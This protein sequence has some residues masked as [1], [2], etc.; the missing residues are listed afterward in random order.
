VENDKL[1]GA[2]KDELQLIL[3]FFPRVESKFSVILAIDTGMI[4]FLAANAPPFS[5][6]SKW[7]LL[8]SGATILLLA[9]SI[10]MLYRGSFPNLKGGESSLVY[11]REIG[12]RREH[13][14]V[15]EFAAQNEK[16]YGHDLLGQVWRNSQI[17]S[18]K[19]D[20]LKLAFTSLALAIPAWI[21]TLALFAAYNGGTHPAVKP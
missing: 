15:E 14:F 6:F 1:I 17:L 4:G 3:S 21:V 8:S 10:A 9:A 13:R 5:A 2:S 7:M 16:Q 19:F 20:C 18:I 11:F 12:K